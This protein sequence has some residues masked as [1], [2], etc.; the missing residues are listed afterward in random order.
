MDNKSLLSKLRAGDPKRFKPVTA[1]CFRTA[2]STIQ[3]ASGISADLADLVVDYIGLLKQAW[4]PDR[5][6]DVE[7]MRDLESPQ[8]HLRVGKWDHFQ[9]NTNSVVFT[10]CLKRL[11]GLRGCN[12][13]PCGLTAIFPQLLTFMNGRGSWAIEKHESGLALYSIEA[14]DLYG[15]SMAMDGEGD[16]ICRRLYKK[17]NTTGAQIGVISRGQFETLQ[18]LARAMRIREEIVARHTKGGEWRRLVPVFELD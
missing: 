11:C 8:R 6:I 9:C 3:N 12:C 18:S 5:Y 17:I 15:L 10:L 7:A 2:S 16:V 13:I 14:Q 1:L 4:R